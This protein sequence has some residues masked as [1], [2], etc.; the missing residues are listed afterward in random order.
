MAYLL[1]TNIISE[2][3]KSNCEPKVRAFIESVPNEDLFTS[4]LVMGEIAYGVKKMPDGKK[5][6]E[7]ASWLN[8]ELPNWFD[9]RIINV[10]LK[11]MLEWGSILADSK[12]TI[13]VMDSLIAAAAVANGLTLVT[14][15]A[16]DFKA[17]EGL[18]LSNPWN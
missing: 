2:L 6:N 14:R 15:N 4:V 9:G 1:D 3:Q 8:T 18:S 16:K 11:T 10:D 17:V 13:P 12:N 5:Q 7:L